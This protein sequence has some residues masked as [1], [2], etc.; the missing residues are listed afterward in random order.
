MYEPVEIS[1]QLCTLRSW[2]SPTHQSLAEKRKLATDKFY[3]RRIRHIHNLHKQLEGSSDHRLTGHDG[4][5][6]GNNETCRL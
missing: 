6:N 3:M 4:S 5:K 2:K 1:S